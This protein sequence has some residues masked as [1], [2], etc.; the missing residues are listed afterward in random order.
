METLIFS[1]VFLAGMYICIQLTW[2]MRNDEEDEDFSTLL[3]YKLDDVYW[4]AAITSPKGEHDTVESSQITVS[5]L[6]STINC[7]TGFSA[8]YIAIDKGTRVS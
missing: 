5:R 7:F 8:S 6:V 1:P 4:S 3:F 2:R